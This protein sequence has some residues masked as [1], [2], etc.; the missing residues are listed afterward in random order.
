MRTENDSIQQSNR[1]AYVEII[2]E[3]KE[4][5]NLDKWDRVVAAS[6]GLLTAMLDVFLVDDLSLRDAH[7][8]GKVK[9]DAFMIKVA[10]SD[11][12]NSTA[13]SNRIKSFQG[14]N[15]SQ[16]IGHLEN[17]FPHA[18]DKSTNEFGGGL[19]HHLRDFGHHPTITGLLFSLISQFSGHGFGT[20]VHGNLIYPEIKDKELIGKN[21][22]E[23]IYLGTINWAFHLISDMAGSSFSSSQGKEGAGIPGPLLSF[24]KEISSVPGIRAIAG[25]NKED[26]YN[27]ALACSKIFNGTLLGTHDEN[28]HPIKGGDLKFDLRTEIGIT[29]EALK[30]KQFIP[31]LINEFIVRAFYAIRRFADEIQK[32][33]IL[34]LSDLKKLDVSHF[35]PWNSK[36]LTR[37][38]MISSTMFSLVDISTAGVK[39]AIKNRNNKTG[40]ALDF[41]Q[42]INYC[43]VGKFALVINSEAMI[44]FGE[45]QNKYLTLA[46]EQISHMQVLGLDGNEAVALLTK[47]ASTGTA[48][49][50]IGTPI[51]FVSAAIGVYQ[52]ISVSVQELEVAREERLRIEAEC[53]EHIVIIRENRAEMEQLVSTY[54]MENLQVFSEAF[55]EMD[56][57]ILNDDPDGF[58]GGNVK[59]QKQLGNKSGFENQHEF[60]DL[61]ATDNSFK[62]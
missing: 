17:L 38:L 52:Q 55:G 45:L 60:E 15:I 44:A 29:N 51:G 61:M 23:K 18:V 7:N 12:V 56:R 30:E 22:T 31:I 19:Q 49:V 47:F 40:F 58:I 32:E 35:R 46:K 13:K 34:C 14:D 43:G 59:I 41:L 48:A 28:G 27:F 53:A 20:D 3:S 9:T 8:W 37:M 6:S 50:K 54:I 1:P 42:G 57:A 10:G 11:F 62:L 2:S 21:P 24:F 16:A 39:A 25:K 26:H 4:V 33:N 5:M 36:P